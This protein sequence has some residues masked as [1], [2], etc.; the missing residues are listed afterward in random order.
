MGELHLE[1]IKDRIV[2]EYKIDAEL[3][4]LQIAYRESPLSQVMEELAEETKIGNSRQFVKTRLSVIPTEKQV[5]D[6]LK[7]DR[8]PEA[9]SNIANIFHKHLI[10]VRKGIDVALCHGPKL[11]FQVI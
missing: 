2:K 5:E 9:A 1:I 7:L 10:A 11:N 8:T 6:V 4:P 3:G